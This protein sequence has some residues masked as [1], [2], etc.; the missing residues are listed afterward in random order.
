M[1]KILITIFLLNS[2]IDFAQKNL[3]PFEKSKGKETA[4]YHECITFYEQLASINPEIKIKDFDSTAAGY[5][6]QLVLYSSNKIFDPAVWRKQEKIIILINN[7]IHP[8]EP[9]GIDASMMLLRDAVEKK[10][11][12][13]QN[14]VLAIIP[15]YNIGGC[16]NRN[17]YSRVN[18]DG[19][20]SYGFRGNEENLDLNRDFIKNDASETKPFE[21]IFQ[22]LNPDIFIDNHVS[23]GADYP[24]TITLL[25]TQHNKLSGEIGEYLHNIF[26]PL[27]YKSMLQKG[28][29]M[30]PYVNAEEN[31]ADGWNAFYDSPRY[32]GG[33][34]A[35]F[36]TMS[37]TVET[38]ML[39]PFADR[40]KSTYDFLQ[41]IA[42]EA[43]AHAVEINARRK[44]AMIASGKQQTFATGWKADTSKY[45]LI[46]FNGYEAAYKTS[47]VTG[48]QRLYYDRT[49]PYKK[50][51]K[52]YNTFIP[53]TTI[54]KPFAYIIPKGWRQVIDLLKLNG[55]V[56]SPLSNDTSMV[57]E[58][59][60]I[61]NYKC[62]QQPYEKHHFNY[63]LQLSALRD[64][65]HLQKGDYIIYTGQRADRY[66]V[67]TL[68]P[69][70]DDSFFK[71]N[72]F[73]A[74]L[75]QKEGYSDYRWED[76]AA[77]YLQQHPEL[78]QQLEEKKKT[79]TAFAKS[80][81]AQLAFVYHNSPYYE[82]AH[83]RYPVFRLIK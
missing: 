80:S 51:V 59:Y 77:S 39:K 7:G 73:D 63:D 26:E 34:A 71:W 79:D 1:K 43:G 17:S 46:D 65:I 75:Q 4:T 5:P 16:L 70:C 74:I 82:K 31:P 45:E 57:L 27:L 14:V 25:T 62:L 24:Y 83:L 61:E 36:Q 42:E 64:T 22:W 20:I 13:P 68:E 60:H 44:N 66:I 37:F 10:I 69:M 23:D 11:T 53:K 28:W 9:D 49:K 29:P 12:I 55:A 2:I 54:Q 35:L 38:H 72:F 50:Q 67:E 56:L 3:T 8:G 76:V 33:Y 47:E 30:C 81:E 18:Q 6:L 52:F 40:V 78:K 48:M 41:S 21:K 32:S 15:V 19:P 58:Y